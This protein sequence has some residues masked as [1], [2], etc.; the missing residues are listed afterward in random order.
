MLV[1]ADDL[2]L[3]KEITP[4]ELSFI[5][6]LEKCVVIEFT[7]AI[8]KLVRIVSRRK[9]VAGVRGTRSYLAL[10]SKLIRSI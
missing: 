8:R 10:L 9:P 1:I 4:K 2:Q 5:C 6:Q 7:V 3:T